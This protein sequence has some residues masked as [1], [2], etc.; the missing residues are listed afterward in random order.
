LAERGGTSDEAATGRAAALCQSWDAEVIA[1]L[2]AER[3]RAVGPERE[4]LLAEELAMEH[5][6]LDRLEAFTGPGSVVLEDRLADL[7]THWGRPLDP[8]AF[9]PLIEA[10]RGRE[11]ADV[12]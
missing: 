7:S 11:P 4:R 6:L 1:P 3:R 5:D 12:G 8:A 10:F 2:R 9:G